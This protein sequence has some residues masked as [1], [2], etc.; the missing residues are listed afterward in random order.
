[1][2]IFR[3]HTRIYP[4]PIFWCGSRKYPY[5][6][7]G[8]LSEGFPLNCIQTK[9]ASLGVRYGYKM[10]ITAKLCRKVPAASAVQERFR[11]VI[12]SKNYGNGNTADNFVSPYTVDFKMQTSH[13]VRL[14]ITATPQAGISF[15]ATPHKKMPNTATPQ[16]PMS[17]SYIYI[18]QI[19]WV[20]LRLD[21]QPLFR[22][23]SLR[24]S[25]R[26]ADRTQERAAEIEPK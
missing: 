12:L 14:E 22:E 24:S 3:K 26:N 21:Y 16:I 5:P 25:G 10:K 7:R 2:D 4:Y 19:D 6:S 18:L 9:K 23:M 17:P 15:T 20:T 13:T 1:M 11:E 8:W